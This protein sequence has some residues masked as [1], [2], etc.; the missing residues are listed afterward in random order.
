[1]DRLFI[2]N[3]Q[4]QAVKTKGSVLKGVSP[5]AATDVISVADFSDIADLVSRAA[6]SGCKWVF[7]E[8]GDGT[9]HGVM[10]AFLQ[11]RAA[12]KTFPQFTLLP[13]GMTNQV[14]RNIGLRRAAP[15]QVEALIKTG[16]GKRYETPLLELD[17]K[18]APPQFG[19]LF[20]TG[21]IPTATEYCVT[22]M[23]DRGV[24]GAAAVAATILR[25]VA[26][27]EKIRNDMMPPSPIKLHVSGNQTQ[28]RIDETHLASIVTTLPGLM[29]GLDPF[30]GAGS[31]PLRL[32]Y[33]RA[34]ARRLL[35][36]AVT[37]WMGR[38]NQ[39]RSKDGFESFTA[40]VL[41]YV[42][43]GPAVLDGEPVKLPHGELTLRATQPV[44]FIA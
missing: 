11:Q 36:N 37:I 40:D 7:I 14:S 22:K 27:S 4:S 30:W 33:A 29:L 18:G 25:G 17:I 5:H 39:N 28:T 24:G 26:G 2:V 3:E 9:V 15:A 38:K 10:T 1:M 19:F 35:Q 16:D 42:Y 43:S 44:S 12:F 20:S 31:G 6:Q 23:Y 21:G 32:T 13:G 41:D 8:G 34:D